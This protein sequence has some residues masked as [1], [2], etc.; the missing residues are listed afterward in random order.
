MKS[1]VTLVLVMSPNISGDLFSSEL[2][3]SLRG[4]VIL[5][6]QPTSRH[7]QMIQYL[8]SPHGSHRLR[9]AG[10]VN[11]QTHARNETQMRC[12]DLFQSLSNVVREACSAKKP[13]TLLKRECTDG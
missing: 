5:L 4:S 2:H 3:P 12:P 10:P 6:S 9:V 8:C 11:T 13:N 1:F 7:Y